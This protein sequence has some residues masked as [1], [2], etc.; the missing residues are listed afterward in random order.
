MNH[1][2]FPLPSEMFH[3]VPDSIDIDE[4]WDKHQ[5]ISELLDIPLKCPHCGEKLANAK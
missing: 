3:Q 4:E 2:G 5:K 1:V